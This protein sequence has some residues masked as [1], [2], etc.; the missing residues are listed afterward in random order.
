M[1]KQTLKKLLLVVVVLIVSILAYAATRPGT[2]H[3]QRSATINASPDKIF[4][5]ITD[6][7]S[8]ASWSPYEKMDPAMNRTYSG[9]PRGQGAVYEWA[10]NSNVGQGR[11]EITDAAPSSKVII[12]LDFIKPIEG[13]DIAQFTLEP[14]GGATNVTWS[15]DGPT[16]F[17]GKVMG[18]F[19]NMDNMIGDQFADGL[20]NLK[21][22]AEK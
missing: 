4:P 7:H 17:V 12:K 3:V 18:I 5:L 14:A 1:L 15:M 19:V 6:F 2:L 22:I 10:G 20:S 16:P 9:A 21:R 8:W 13:H 11:M